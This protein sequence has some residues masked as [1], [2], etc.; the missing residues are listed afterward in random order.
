MTSSE[1]PYTVA[2]A[3]LDLAVQALRLDLGIHEILKYPKKVVTTSLPVLL[4][5]GSVKVFRGYRVQHHDVR[6][7]FKGGIRYHPSVG[8]DE[9]KAL[10][11]WMTWKCAVVDLPFGGAK[12]GVVC[13]P[14][15]M[16]EG[17][18]ERVTRRFTANLIPVIG[19][20]TDILAPDV[21]TTPQTMSWIM[22]TYSTYMGVSSPGVVTGKPI[23]IGG[24]L[25]RFEATGRG[26]SLV[27]REAAK[28]QKLPLKGA[29]VVVQGYGNV[30]Y[31]SAKLLH[32]MGCRILAVSDSKGGVYNP[33]GLDPEEVLRSKAQTGSVQGFERGEAITNPELL[34]LE[35]DILIPSA[36]EN[37][38][39]QKNADAI[40]ARMIVEGANGPTTPQADAI[41]EERDVLVI[42]DILAN[43]GGVTVSYFEWVQNG[44]SYFWTEKGVDLELK[45]KMVS[46]FHEVRKIAVEKKVSFRLAAYMLAVGRVAEAIRLR[47]IFP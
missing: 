37:Q 39:T 13:N 45:K 42:P 24:S 18:L 19:P 43:A 26:L 41:L 5:D 20:K 17:E 1:N 10:A 40:Q 7:P 4:D 16:S 33:D 32:R 29:S 14:K 31:I 9:M 21:Y 30:G 22:D 6:G 2:L 15:E 38:I 34:E 25:G 27:T 35:C 23:R 28:V 47:G 12:G 3:Q 36:L 44:Q 11:M 46:S 8:L